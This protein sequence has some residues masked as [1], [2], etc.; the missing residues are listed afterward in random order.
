MTITGSVFIISAPSGTGKTSL[1]ASLRQAVLGIQKSVSHTT[2]QPRT[3]E[4]D[5]KHYHF[6]TVE[7]FNEM[8]AKNVFLEHA[9][10]FGNYY[11]TSREWILQ[12]ISHGVDVVL[13]IDWQGAQQIKQKM[14]EVV[15][16]FILPPNSTSLRSRLTQRKQDSVESIEQRLEEASGEIAHFAEYDYLVVNDNFE[17]AL[18]D[19]VAIVTSVRLRCERQR[20]VL[21]HLLKDLSHLI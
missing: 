18:N 21:R 3:Q 12:T 10:V 9:K 15:T 13:E 8:L 14:P 5:G 2:R 4:V 11:G 7:Q 6:V 16:I 19:L 1:A 17:H 20:H